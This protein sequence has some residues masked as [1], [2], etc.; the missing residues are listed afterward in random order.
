MW[1]RSWKGILRRAAAV[2]IGWKARFAKLFISMRVLASEGKTS[3]GEA[4][5]RVPSAPRGGFRPPDRHLPVDSLVATRSARGA[6]GNP[7]LE[8]ATT[9]DLAASFAAAKRITA[10]I[11]AE[12]ARA[13]GAQTQSGRYN[14]KIIGETAQHL[15]QRLSPQTAVAHMKHLFEHIPTVSDNVARARQCAGAYTARR[16]TGNTASF[17]RPRIARSPVAALWGN[18]L[19]CTRPPAEEM[20]V[21]LQVGY[22]VP[23]TLCELT[24][25]TCAH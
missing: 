21:G 15:V 5:P 4:I 12:A 16:G 9:Q 8:A 7:S 3:G 10:D 24:D 17:E 18:T 20:P 23:P 13:F 19:S 2:R 25:D 11:L 6:D 1:R 14:G 22:S